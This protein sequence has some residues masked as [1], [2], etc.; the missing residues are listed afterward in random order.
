MLNNL[1]NVL[2]IFQLNLGNRQL[3]SAWF[4]ECL[5]QKFQ[6]N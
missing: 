5:I 4:R 6:M 3:V 2:G 1:K